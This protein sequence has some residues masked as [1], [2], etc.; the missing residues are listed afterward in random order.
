MIE[1][2][3]GR[4][5]LI[6]PP[7][8]RSI[9]PSPPKYTKK[10]HTNTT[11]KNTK[12]PQ[13]CASKPPIC[14]KNLKCTK[15]P[16]SHQKTPKMYQ[17]PPLAPATKFANPPPL[18]FFVVRKPGGRGSGRGGGGVKGVVGICVYRHTA[19]RL[20]PG[21]TRPGFCPPRGRGSFEPS[22][23]FILPRDGRVLQSIQFSPA[24]VIKPPCMWTLRQLG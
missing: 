11:P 14:K 19:P 5:S 2:L 12:K 8:P 10:N 21:V 18:G 20:I 9:P 15:N 17:P 6:L 4:N 13:R 1:F 7:P 16:H 22:K 24:G 3:L 23:N